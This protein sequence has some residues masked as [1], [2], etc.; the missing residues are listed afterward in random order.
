MRLTADEARILADALSAA[1]KDAVVMIRSNNFY[2]EEAA[3]AVATKLQNLEDRLM[4]HSDDGR[5]MERR[6]GKRSRFINVL[7]RYSNIKP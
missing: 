7:L 6:T 4:Q 3:A 1:K 5:R 2:S